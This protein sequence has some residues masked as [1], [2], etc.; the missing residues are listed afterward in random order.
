M[1]YKIRHQVQFL[2][3]K[4]YV[5]FGTFPECLEHLCKKVKSAATTLIVYH[6]FEY[7]A[8]SKWA[9]RI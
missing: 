7:L 3:W 6:H 2:E 9:N 4:P 8:V 1:K 5:L